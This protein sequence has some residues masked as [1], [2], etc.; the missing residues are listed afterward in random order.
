MS[1]IKEIFVAGRLDGRVD[2]LPLTPGV[3]HR[4]VVDRPLLL[5]PQHGTIATR[6]GSALV[7]PAPWTDGLHPI[8]FILAAVHAARSVED[9]VVLFVG[10]NAEGEPAALADARSRCIRCI[11]ERDRNGWVSLATDHGGLDDIIA[12][13]TYLADVHGWPTRPDQENPDETQRNAEAVTAFQ[14]EYN[15]VHSADILVDGVCGRQTLG[16]VFDVLLD[17]WERWLVKHDLSQADVDALDLH[18]VDGSGTQAAKK[19]RLGAA[20]GL[21]SIVVP[22]AALG[23]AE[24]TPE[25]L[26]TSTLARHTEYLVPEEPGAWAR[27]PYTIVT[28]LL[29]DE[30]H[31]REL[32]TLVS[33]DGEFEQ[34][35]VLPGDAEDEGVLVLKFSDLPTDKHY[36]LSVT[37]H[38]REVFELFADVPY[39]QLHRLATEDDA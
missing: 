12:Y 36:T 9:P 22:R 25:L 8:S 2:P 39:P 15:T 10:H 38:E 20:P 23:E 28:D 30:P 29:A 31:A 34:Q 4:I 7:M 11:I 1:S 18:F 16:A 6:P 24:P 3:H 27:G 26:Y 19:G 35:R 21:H 37:V 13:L 32:Y 33:T 14:A 5:I 17:E